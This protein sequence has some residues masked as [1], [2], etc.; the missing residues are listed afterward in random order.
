MS[1]R[2]APRLGLGRRLLDLVLRAELRPHAPSW[3][4]PAPGHTLS[5][6]HT[7]FS[8]R[9]SRS[10]LRLQVVLRFMLAG[11]T[12]TGD[13]ERDGKREVDVHYSMVIPWF[14]RRS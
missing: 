14:I 13:G 1:P 7:L 8:A 5:V 9:G 11:E 2:H 12:E 10:L 6:C 3:A 4:G